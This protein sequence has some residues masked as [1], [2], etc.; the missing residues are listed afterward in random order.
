VTKIYR[1][2]TSSRSK[3]EESE[4]EKIA[5]EAVRIF[6]TMNSVALEV[7]IHFSAD[8]EFNKRNRRRFATA[9]ASLVNA[10]APTEDG[11]CVLQNDWANPEMF[12]YEVDSIGIYRLASLKRNIWSVASAGFVQEDFVAENASRD[13]EERR[14]H[15]QLSNLLRI[16]ATDRVRLGRR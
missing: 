14:A 10:Y 8:N 12:P 7:K 3:R 5:N 4:Q 11:P 1:Q 16:L 2:A 15:R 9:I 6:E 13:H